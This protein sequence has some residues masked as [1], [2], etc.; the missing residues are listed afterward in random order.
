MRYKLS[1]E[2]LPWENYGYKWI[3]N[4][5][6][7]VFIIQLCIS[8]IEYNDQTN[9]DHSQDPF[10]YCA[11]GCTVKSIRRLRDDKPFTYI[12]GGAY[13]KGTYEVGKPIEHL[14]F[15]CKSI[16][17]LNISQGRKIK[18][19]MDAYCNII[20]LVHSTEAQSK[21]EML[22]RI[23]AITKNH[24]VLSIQEAREYKNHIDTFSQRLQESAAA[25]RALES[26]LAKN[27]RRE[28]T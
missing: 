26:L 28:G 3:A 16:H 18:E 7:D 4:S 20:D 23:Q 1:F 15:Y 2:K 6:C 12:S 21:S 14:V 27:Q 10:C 24:S 22:E 19:K 11:K 8:G 5:I 9:T 25:K 13:L 17:D